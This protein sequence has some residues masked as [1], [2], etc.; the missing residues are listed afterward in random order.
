VG[1]QAP[2][3]SVIFLNLLGVGNGKKGEPSR[4]WKIF[5]LEVSASY[6]RSK[7]IFNTASRSN[8]VD[9]NKDICYLFSLLCSGLC[10]KNG[11]V[12]GLTVWN[13]SLWKKCD[14]FLENI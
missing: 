14:F 4:I 10:L 6:V 9:G 2:G 13:W 3:I 1:T 8:C 5:S 11:I 12:Y 7:V